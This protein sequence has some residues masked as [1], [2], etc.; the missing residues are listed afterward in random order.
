MQ[1][2]RGHLYFW[3]PVDDVYVRDRFQ[4][5]H[6]AVRGTRLTLQIVKGIPLLLGRIRHELGSE[7]LTE[8]CIVGSPSQPRQRAHG[9]KLLELLG[10]QVAMLGANGE[11]A[12]KN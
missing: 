5:A 4:I 7:H 12:I 6:G 9:S 3:Q 1:Y 10:R 11:A 8:G 2:Q